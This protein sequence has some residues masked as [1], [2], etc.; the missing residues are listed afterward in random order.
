MTRASHSQ[1]NAPGDPLK[2]TLR[3]PL[4]DHPSVKHWCLACRL[5]IANDQA[6]RPGPRDAW[7]A[8]PGAMPGSL[9]RTG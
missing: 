7:I 8:N 5:F 2:P 9:Q 4:L 3:E 6:Q 1:G